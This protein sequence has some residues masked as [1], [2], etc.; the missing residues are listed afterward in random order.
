MRSIKTP[1][2]QLLEEFTRRARDVN[3]ARNATFTIFYAFD[4][5]CGLA[6]LG[7]IRAFGGVHYLFAVCSFCDLGAWCHG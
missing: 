4:D 2:L 7:A 3:P 1:V 5:P 6:A